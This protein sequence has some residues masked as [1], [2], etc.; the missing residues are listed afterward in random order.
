LIFK[1]P[2]GQLFDFLVEYSPMV[3]TISTSVKQCGKPGKSFTQS[4]FD[5][6]HREEVAKFKKDI[7]Q[8]TSEDPFSPVI[9]FLKAL[10]IGFVLATICSIS[11][12]AYDPGYRK[13]LRTT[14]PLAA[15][16]LD[17]IMEKEEDTVLRDEKISE[18]AATIR[19]E[20]KKTSES[21]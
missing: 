14:Y 11:Y 4:D 8:I 13:V 19:N 7:E 12:G 16:F 1:L 20:L 15:N 17:L 10:T 9:Y 3:A 18:E 21:V 2:S 5:R 6:V